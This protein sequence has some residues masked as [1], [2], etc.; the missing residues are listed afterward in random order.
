MKIR[1]R[2][3]ELRKDYEKKSGA[4]IKTEQQLFEEGNGF[5]DKKL[6]D[7]L[8]EAKASLQKAERIYHSFVSEIVSKKL[9]VN[10]EM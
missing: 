6:L 10:A 8:A 7:D 9:N 4:Y 5:F 1:D 2:L 3:N